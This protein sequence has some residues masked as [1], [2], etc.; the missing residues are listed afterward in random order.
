MIVNLTF[1]VML[2]LWNSLA[3][4]SSPPPPPKL[5]LNK[6]VMIFLHIMK[7]YINQYLN[8]LPPPPALP[9]PPPVK[10]SSKND[11]N[12][13]EANLE[14]RMQKNSLKLN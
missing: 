14:N 9:P 2:C 7:T 4:R 12:G 11:S 13:S 5:N 3:S 8:P 1:D 6:V 10:K